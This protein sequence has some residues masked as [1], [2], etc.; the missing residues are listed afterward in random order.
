MLI[1]PTWLTVVGKGHGYWPVAVL[2]TDAQ[3]E[4]ITRI[5][6]VDDKGKLLSFEQR[7]YDFPL[8]PSVLGS[9]HVRGSDATGM[10]SSQIDAIRSVSAAWAVYR[11]RNTWKQSADAT[12]GANTGVCG[13]CRLRTTLPIHF[14]SSGRLAAH[15][16]SLSNAYRL[17]RVLAV[18]LAVGERVSA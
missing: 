3:K 10:E 18:L 2:Q 12:N 4:A 16:V 5:E 17:L 8:G 14:S 1:L 11:R 13:G 9:V 6:E 15:A 7:E